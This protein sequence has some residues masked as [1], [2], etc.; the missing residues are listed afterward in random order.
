MVRPRTAHEELTALGPVPAW[1][2][3]AVATLRG[4]VTL[5]AERTSALA[6]ATQQLAAATQAAEALPV[7]GPAV[8]L[9]E[10]IDAIAKQA[11]TELQRRERI[12]EL[13]PRL[14]AHRG[15]VGAALELLGPGHDLAWLKEQAPRV[16]DAAGLRTVAATTDHARQQA[17]AASAAHRRVTAELAEEAEDLQHAATTAAAAGGPSAES[18]AR[19]LDATARL[20]ALVGQRDAATRHLAA[21]SQRTPAPPAAQPERVR[22]RGRP[23]AIAGVIAVVAAL[24][25]LG[26]GAPLAAAVTVVVG[27]ALVA[28]GAALGLGARTAPAAASAAATTATVDPLTTHVTDEIAQLDAE[29]VPVLAT[30]E[31][32]HTPTA[33]QAA[34]IQSH[35]HRLAS[36]AHDRDAAKRHTADRL[37]A[38]Q[39]S[40]ARRAAATDADVARTGRALTE[41][42]Q[43]WTTWLGAHHLPTSLDPAG[44][45]EF[46]TTV[47]RARTAAHAATLVEADLD[48]AQ[49]QSDAFAA[50]VAPLAEQL[51]LDPHQDPLTT[52]DLLATAARQAHRQAQ[53]IEQAAALVE[54]RRG[55][56]DQAIAHLD[57]ADAELKTLLGEVSVAD[58]DDAL[59]QIERVE[60]AR[61]LGATIDEAETKLAAA[62]GP[63]DEQ[64]RQARNLLTDPDADPAVWAAQVRQLSHQASAAHQQRDGVLQQRST[65]QGQV[66][67]LSASADIASIEL[68]V[69]D[70]ETQLVDAVTQWA[71]FHLAHQMVE[72]TLAR[73]QRERQPEV[74]QRAGTLFEQVTDGRYTRLEVRGTE[75]V[76]INRAAQEVPAT[77]LSQGTTEQLYLCMRFALAESFSKTASL[78]LLL[79]DITV[80]ADAE[81]LPRLAQMIATVAETNQVLVFSCQ[82]R[83]VELL[84][85]AD[86]QARTITLPSQHHTSQIG[87]AVS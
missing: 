72:G 59:D 43:A 75:V 37:D 41:A 60:H 87:R 39:R 21:A 22:P 55:D 11:H 19:Y 48:Q 56:R 81:R 66:D 61:R 58:A 17:E 23:V 78:P 14:A 64:L 13:R 62:L 15:E 49:G 42:Q 85:Q 32:D 3:R 73:Y 67:V 1:D 52:V 76:A 40:A 57:R 45:A 25:L 84:Q 44:A 86:P 68:R 10:P 30:L 77:A 29:L 18:A 24:V 5:R 2:Q 28:G 63:A 4:A 50:A 8:A 6:S 9:A 36:A 82:D 53:A 74:V 12:A 54:H 34:E 46:L 71:S 16:E 69:T 31:L 35:A 70:L 38:H 79:D 83:M 26:A 47:D 7:P 80:N 20:V 33:S 27:L 65:V 51:G